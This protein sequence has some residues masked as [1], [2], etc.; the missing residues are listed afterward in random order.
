M[1]KN[2]IVFYISTSNCQE[3]WKYRQKMAPERLIFLFSLRY[4]VFYLLH[5]F[6]WKKKHLSKKLTI[7]KLSA[8]LACSQFFLEPM[9]LTYLEKL[10]YVEKCA[11]SEFPEFF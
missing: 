5:E 10:P 6:L 7:P 9:A 1:T 8:I 11:Y 2:F 3:K 4:E